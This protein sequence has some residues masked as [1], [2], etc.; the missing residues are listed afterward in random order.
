MDDVS[1][2]LS[3][4]PLLL[5]PRPVVV[6]IHDA[7]LHLGEKRSRSSMVRALALKSVRHLVLH[8]E[9]TR[10]QL[11]RNGKKNWNCVVI[12]LG[13][14]D[15]FRAW[16]TDVPISERLSIL[17]FGRLSA[18]K[19]LDIFIEAV[20]KLSSRL[21]DTDFI[22]AGRPV[23]G[24]QIPKIP[25]LDN[26]NR[27]ITRFGYVSNQDL[28]K[29][30][31]IA[32]FVVVPYLEASQS[33]VILTAY[34][35]HKPVV[36][37]SVGGIPEV[38]EDRKTGRLVPPGDPLALA[39]AMYELSFDPEKINNMIGN[40]KRITQEEL[41]WDNLTDR[42]YAFYKQLLKLKNQ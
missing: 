25:N 28:C 3:S 32:T 19:G 13:V 9:F 16:E 22:I 24:Y 21:T 37:T 6:T 33:G 34:A 36:A 39:E 38:V 31:N 40:I 20:K 5:Y 1:S 18:Y 12:P 35:F 29:L 15:V 23:P 42:T 30:F 8:S 4:L 26:G 17:F 27:F 14:L 2:R 11:F 10:S 7:E 41:S